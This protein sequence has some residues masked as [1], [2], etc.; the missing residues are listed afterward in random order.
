MT[1]NP[2]LFTL[3]GLSYLA[4]LVINLYKPKG[5]GDQLVGWGLIVFG[6]LAAYVVCSLMLTIQVAYKGGFGWIA[7]TKVK[8]NIIV[9]LMWLCLMA[10]VVHV[11]LINVDWKAAGT[12]NGFGLVMVHY[13]AIWLPL[14]MLVPYAIMVNPDWQSGAYAAIYKLMLLM[15]CIIGLT[16][17]FTPRQQLGKWFKDQK[18]IKEMHYEKAMKDIASSIEPRWLLYDML[19]HDDVRIQKAAIDKL[20]SLK[21]LEPQ[22]VELLNNYES[23]ADYLYVYAFLEKYE[24]KEPALFVEP[25]N[26]TISR[27]AEELKYRPQSFGSEEDFLKLLNVEG[28]CR[29]LDEQFSANKAEFLTNMLKVKAEL[30]TTPKPEYVAICNQYKVAVNNWLNKNGGQR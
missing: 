3:T 26:K 10:G 27:V 22:L 8:R 19:N 29:V 11:S 16:F 9:G 20:V 21:N 17:H 30:E 13:G 25:L 2:I 23:S 28:L 4:L 7:E 12:A 1:A 18:A 5:T 15:G 14:L 6:V 24:V